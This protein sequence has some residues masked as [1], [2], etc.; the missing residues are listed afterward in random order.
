MTDK[1]PNKQFVFID[2][3][4][5]QSNESHNDF[6][7]IVN[8]DKPVDTVCMIRAVIKKSYYLVQS[9][10]NT[11]I[12]QEGSSSA[13]ITLQEGNY[14]ASSFKTIVQALLNTNSPT[15]WTYTISLPNPL[16]QA[17]TAKF[18]YTVTG[19]SGVQPSFIFSNN[20]CE[21]FGFNNNTTNSFVSNTLTSSNV[22]NFQLKDTLRI[23]SNIVTD[24]SDD[25]LQ[26]VTA[27]SNADFSSIRYECL[28]IEAN[29]K[30]FNI[31][32]N[33]FRFV[34]LDEDKNTVNLSL[35]CLYTLIFYLKN[36]S[37]DIANKISIPYMQL[38]SK[39]K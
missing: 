14:S 35:N 36:T 17:S 9:G 29:S 28:D 13:T 25:I 10:Y 18:T 12:L 6:S 26:E 22:V 3:H 2:S 1:Y 15:G 11:F 8:L 32:T 16:T 30:P 20:L 5:K 34:V 38:M 4:N 21:Q 27:S 19:N 31:K 37:A 39:K 33:N 24:S 7:V 23:H